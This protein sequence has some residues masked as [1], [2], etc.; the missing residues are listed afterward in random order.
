M[1]YY[2]F[3]SYKTLPLDYLPEEAHSVVLSFRL[4]FIQLLS[5]LLI[6]NQ[7]KT[8]EKDSDCIY[9]RILRVYSDF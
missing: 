9:K 6:E 8:T 2:P 3:E 5:V 1:F 7:G 4:H